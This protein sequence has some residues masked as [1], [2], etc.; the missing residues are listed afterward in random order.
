MMM[1]LVE[2]DKIEVTPLHFSKA[3]QDYFSVLVPNSILFAEYASKS[4][5]SFL[6]P[7]RSNTNV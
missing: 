7:S 4:V 5:N 2:R 3:I 1:L 6:W